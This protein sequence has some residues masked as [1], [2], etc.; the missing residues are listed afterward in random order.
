MQY[1]KD[2][3]APCDMRGEMAFGFEAGTLAKDQEIERCLTFLG[4]YNH[5]TH[6]TLRANSVSRVA[7]VFWGFVAACAL[8][9][10]FALQGLRV[11]AWQQQAASARAELASAQAALLDQQ[12]VNHNSVEDLAACR[13]AVE[14]SR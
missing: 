7:F 10:V 11:S 2:K 12:A 13:I 5:P 8:I 3:P 14:R 6:G 4:Y 1:T 9:T